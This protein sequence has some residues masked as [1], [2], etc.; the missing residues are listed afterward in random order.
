M[1]IAARTRTGIHSYP[2]MGRREFMV[3]VGVTL[4]ACHRAA[5]AQSTNHFRRLGIFLDLPE[6]DRVVP[7]LITP[8]LQELERLGWKDGRNIRIE[9]RGTDG[10]AGRARVYAT[11]LVNLKPDIILINSFDNLIALHQETRSIP[12]VF[13]QLTNVVESGMVAS[14]AHPGG[15]ITGFTREEP[16]IGGKWLQLLREMA[17]HVTQVAVIHNGPWTET[18]RSIEV[19]ATALRVQLHQAR[20]SGAADTEHAIDVF[21]NE[22]NGG[23]IVMPDSNS[24]KHREQ[25]IALAALYGLPAIYANRIY[26]ADGGLMSYGADQVGQFRRAA[27]YVDSILKGANPADLAVQQPT[28]FE[29]VINRMTAKALGLTIPQTL[30]ARTDELIE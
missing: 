14:L 19:M 29:L 2:W 21:A 28:K 6:S 30:L 10:D 12:V 24:A 3:L 4:I 16:G 27:S 25:I 11:E 9:Y 18:M 22:P 15:N 7:S 1:A 5:I 20:V 17:P 23:L 13:V 26:V 8:F